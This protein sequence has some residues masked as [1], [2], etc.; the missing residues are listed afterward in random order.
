MKIDLPNN[1]GHVIV[2]RDTG[3]LLSILVKTK[4]GV[5]YRGF[6]SYTNNHDGTYSKRK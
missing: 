4:G 2:D 5:D 3:E 6:A 1:Q